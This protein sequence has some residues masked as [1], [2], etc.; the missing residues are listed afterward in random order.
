ID[1]L[2]GNGLLHRNIN[3]TTL[4]WDEEDKQV[5]VGHF[6]C[7]GTIAARRQRIGRGAITND[8]A[9]PEAF[10]GERSAN[11]DQYSLALTYY[12]LRVGKLPFLGN[13]LKRRPNPEL[14]KLTNAERRIVAQALHPD[15]SKRFPSCSAFIG[16]LAEAL[17]VEP[18]AD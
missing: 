10:K 8:Y 2:N 16:K 5:K 4:L 14:P 1:C 18:E 7:L 6:D 3:P 9:P 15:P 17:G 12:E 11:W 13:P